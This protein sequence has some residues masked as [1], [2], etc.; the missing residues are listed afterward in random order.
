MRDTYNI[1]TT[2][3]LIEK[4]EWSL[5]T[6]TCMKDTNMNLKAEKNNI[7]DKYKQLDNE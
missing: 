4:Y 7:T 5:E 6:N 1:N 3:D 2:K